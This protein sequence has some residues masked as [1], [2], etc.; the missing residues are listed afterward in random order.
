MES[1]ISTSARLLLSSC[2]LGPRKK[3]G[4]RRYTIGGRKK[5]AGVNPTPCRMD[6]G[7]VGKGGAGDLYLCPPRCRAGA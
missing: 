6:S 2:T 5:F 3:N 1:L 7:R 4:Q